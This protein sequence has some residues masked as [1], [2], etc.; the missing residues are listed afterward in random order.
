M[1]GFV[2][3]AVGASLV[4]VV[5]AVV[6]DVCCYNKRK[7]VQAEYRCLLSYDNFFFSF[8]M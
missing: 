6:V 2:F 8:K 4:V 3:D 7:I 5:V 1:A